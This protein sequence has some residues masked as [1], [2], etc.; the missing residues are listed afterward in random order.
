MSENTHQDEYRAWAAKLETLS[1]LAVR[2]FLGTRPEGDPRVDYLAGLEAFKNVATAQ[3]A[4]LTMIVTTL[5][6]DNVETLR[7]AGLAELQGQIE[8]MEKDLAVTGWD[9]DGNPLFDLPASREL[10]K[11]WPE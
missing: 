11:G 8:S 9:G 2:Q 6:G 10:T 7:K 5:L 3:I 1:R 4:A